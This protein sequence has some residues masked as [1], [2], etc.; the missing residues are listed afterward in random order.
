MV[1]GAS[2]EEAFLQ[3][4]LRNRTVTRRRRRAADLDPFLRQHP[5]P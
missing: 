4:A 3:T 1:V 2:F 5:A